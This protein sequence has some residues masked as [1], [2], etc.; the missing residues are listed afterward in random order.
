MRFRTA[1]APHLAPSTSVSGTMLGVL[2]A[3]VPGLLV[4]AW[5]FGPAVLIQVMIAL[6][7][8]ETAESLMLTWRGKAL[9]HALSDLSA[10]VTAVL[11][12]VSI[13]PLLPWGLTVFGTCFAIVIG[14]QLY[15]GLGHNPF[16]PAMVGYAVLLVSFPKWMS[17]WLP[18]VDAAGVHLGLAET[19]SLIF[20]HSVATGLPLDAVT[21]ATPLDV[22]RTGLRLHRSLDQIRLGTGVGAAT[23]GWAAVNLAYLAGGLWLY[24]RRLIG[25]QIPVAFLG[26]LFAVSLVFFAIDPAT[27]PSPLFH[28]F[29][30]GTMLGAFFIA[31][32]PVTAA[33]TAKGR[34]IFGS[35]AGLLVFV[36]RSWGS[37]PD[38][39][40]FAV[41]LGNLAAPSIDHWFRPQVQGRP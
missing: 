12:A 2:L 10:L 35:L 30:G 28:L 34:W 8:A 29:S 26:A 3:L 39:I 31:T 13:P 40:A 9:R 33:T 21:G 15:G 27:H 18:P 41:L 14:K 32:D 17:Q 1:H 25:R 23:A 20:R 7:A 38:G 16:N 5:Q 6:L 24:R 37:Y 4:Q 22:V 11:L 36:I 19:A